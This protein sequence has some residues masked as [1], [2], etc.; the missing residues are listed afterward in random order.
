MMDIEEILFHVQE[1][2]GREFMYGS[3]AIRG[4]RVFRLIQRKIR[5]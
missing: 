1:A 2:F 5:W 3:K 4:A